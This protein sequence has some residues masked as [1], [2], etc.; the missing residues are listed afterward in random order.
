[1]IVKNEIEICEIW[2]DIWLLKVQLL[3]FLL[4]GL[5]SGLFID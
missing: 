3:F 5:F 4:N 2:L 1:M